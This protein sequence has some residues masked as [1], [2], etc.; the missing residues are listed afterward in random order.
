MLRLTTLNAGDLTLSRTG[1]D[2]Q[3][4]VNATGET[5]TVE[6]Q[7]L[8]Q[9]SNYG[10]KRMQFAGGSSWDLAT[11]NANAWLRGTDGNDTIAGT[12]WNDTLFGKIWAGQSSEQARGGFRLGVR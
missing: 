3:V 1:L 10:I 2:M 7:F 9:T 11:I 6:S 5:I 12:S 4:K 8:S